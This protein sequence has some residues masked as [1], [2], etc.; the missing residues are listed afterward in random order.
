MLCQ[1][2]YCCFNLLCRLRLGEVLGEGA[3]G[4]VMR[5]VADDIA[6]SLAET[7]V[8]VKMLRG[9]SCSFETSSFRHSF[10]HPIAARLFSYFPSL[11]SVSLTSLL[12]S[13]LS[14]VHLH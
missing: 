10:L 6:G 14:T 9:I 8:A 12:P 2:C 3:F 4:I 7:T 11:H 13:P 1:V 5:A